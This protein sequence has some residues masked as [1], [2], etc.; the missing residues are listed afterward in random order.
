[1]QRPGE[2]SCWVL[3][4]VTAVN[5]DG[6]SCPVSLPAGAASASPW[7]RRLTLR[8]IARCAPASSLSLA[9]ERRL[10]LWHPPFRCSAQP[11]KSY[12]VAFGANGSLG[13]LVSRRLVVGL[14]QRSSLSASDRSRPPASHRPPWGPQVA[15]GLRNCSGSRSVGTMSNKLRFVRGL[16]AGAGLPMG[17]QAVLDP[18]PAVPC[19]SQT[20]LRRG[21]APR[22]PRPAPLTD[23]VRC[24]AFLCRFD[25]PGYGASCAGLGGRADAAGGQGGA[26]RRMRISN[27]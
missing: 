22:A 3:D 9:V 11:A 23:A 7:P 8:S 25:S 21:P 16:L 10:R 1:M 4:R 17:P 12:A 20:P 24:L 15:E 14:G 13:S 26:S 18:S 6:A 19:G 27:N 5:A 2:H